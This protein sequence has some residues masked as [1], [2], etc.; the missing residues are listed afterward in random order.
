MCK[1]RNIGLTFVALVL[2]FSANA[3]PVDRYV[4]PNCKLTPAISTSNYPGFSSIPNGNQLVQPAGKAVSYTANP[5]YVYGRVFDRNCVPVSDAK[6][7][8]WHTNAE[9]RYRFATK[10]V[11][12]SAQPVFTG[13]GRATTDNLGQFQFVTLYPGP[14]S[15]RVKREDESYYRIYRAPHLNVSVTHKGLRKFSTNLFFEG[16]DDNARDHRLKRISDTRKPR[17][18]MQAYPVSGVLRAG[19]QVMIDIVLP[20][21]QAFRK[22]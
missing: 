22:F 15:Y 20:D 21:A 17:V 5:L 18:M 1:P 2:S 11:L 12:A 6:L 14:Y 9:G 16:E 7:E 4:K 19:Q 13:A 10:A 8:L 3:N